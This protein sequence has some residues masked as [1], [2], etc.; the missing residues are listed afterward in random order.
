MAGIINRPSTAGFDYSLDNTSAS[1]QVASQ[2]NQS[3][4]NGRRVIAARQIRLQAIHAQIASAEVTAK[5]IAQRELQLEAAAQPMVP[6]KVAKSLRAAGSAAVAGMALDILRN[7]KLPGPPLSRQEAL[8]QHLALQLAAAMLG[9]NP[10]EIEWLVAASLV[11]GKMPT[12]RRELTKRLEDAAEDP[13]AFSALFSEVLESGEDPE[14]VRKLMQAA[15][16]KPRQ[17][18][19]VLREA[20]GLNRLP[21]FARRNADPEKL[22]RDI[23]EAGDNPELVIALVS[24]L[25]GAGG[26]PRQLAAEL[27]ALRGDARKLSER[28]RRLVGGA[29]SVNEERESLLENVNSALHELEL[30]EGDT[31]RRSY[32]AAET[33]SESE[34]PARFLEA[35]HDVAAEQAGFSNVLRALLRHYPA[36][37]LGAELSNMKK[38]LGD[39]LAMA[40]SLRDSDRLRV[41]LQD[42]SHM[43]LSTSLLMMVEQFREN[44]AGAAL[45]GGYAA[46]PIDSGMLMRELI[47]VVDTPMVQTRHFEGLLKTLGIS[48]N[49]ETIV[50]LQGMMAILREMPDR[51]FRD[52]NT[53]PTL[54]KTAQQVLDAAILREEEQ[55]AAPVA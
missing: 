13:E 35:F 34:E 47:D 21:E 55:Q 40:N 48:G 19:A 23:I 25:E 17:M 33:A 44:C 20:L 15:K 37:K 39:E 41:I 24:G 50:A 12:S 52:A 54:L 36:D 2:Q 30:Q 29:G 45:A 28:L 42:I 26:N 11:K 10:D 51:I 38:A 1:H 18:A 9:D 5:S 32:Q 7:R 43:H 3:K 46:K 49:Q 14:N 4:I 6:E 16:R 27:T 8:Q 22:A 31:I 53:L